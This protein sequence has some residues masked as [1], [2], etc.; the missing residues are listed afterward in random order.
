MVGVVFGI[1]VVAQTVLFD[2]TVLGMMK[3]EAELATLWQGLLKTTLVCSNHAASLLG[4]MSALAMGVALSQQ[5]AGRKGLM[6]TLYGALALGM[7]LTLSRGG[8]L[9]WA[10]SHALLWLML[11]GHTSNKRRGTMRSR[12]RSCSGWAT[13][14]CEMC[15]TKPSPN[16]SA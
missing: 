12:V 10:C 16:G 11:R 6:L 13:V 9:A 15:G 5:D 2:G 8:I 14:I 7:C 1:A 3:P 4:V